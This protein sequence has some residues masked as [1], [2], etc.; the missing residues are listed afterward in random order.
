MFAQ[1]QV[2]D[3]SGAPLAGANVFE[4]DAFGSAIN[5][6]GTQTTEAG[7]YM[8]VGD[9]ESGYVTA[10]YVGYKPQ[11]LP[12]DAPLNFHLQSDNVLPDVVVTPAPPMNWK[13][14]AEV[15]I[16]AALCATVIWFA[17]THLSR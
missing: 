7:T 13:E 12:V 6:N 5:G 16:I 3:S 1:G 10:S 11:T 8:L 17:F 2:Y 15:A 9:I 14:F 4:S